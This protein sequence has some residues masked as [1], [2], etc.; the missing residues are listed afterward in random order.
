MDKK[1]KIIEAYQEA[2]KAIKLTHE[3]AKDSDE[4]Y[5]KCYVS[6][7]I[8]VQIKRLSKKLK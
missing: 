7:A 8:E 2:I 4:F 1:D 5:Y 3:S 6:N